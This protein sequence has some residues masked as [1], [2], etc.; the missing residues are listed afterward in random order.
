MKLER[1]TRIQPDARARASVRVRFR[2]RPDP[3]GAGH[4]RDA[5]RN[6]NCVICD[7]V[8][9]GRAPG[10]RNLRRLCF[11]IYI[12]GE[13]ARRLGVH[14]HPGIVWDEITGFAVTMLAV[15]A[16]HCTGCWP[17]SR[18]SGCW[19]SGSPGRSG[20]LITVSPAGWELCLMTYRGHFRGSDSAR[21]AVSPLVLVSLAAPVRPT[22][23]EQ[24]SEAR[25]V[26]WAV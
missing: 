13:S 5:D 23:S 8:R 2:L 20:R 19:T 11:G 6:S 7:A 12:C 14:D 25:A 18:C 4:I 21:H 24:R 3:V 16:Q 15:P 1:W 10:F 17:V 9:L 22:M 26:R